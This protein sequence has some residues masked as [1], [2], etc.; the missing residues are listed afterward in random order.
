MYP[1]DLA[2]PSPEDF[3]TPNLT[4]KNYFNKL[5]PSV[6]PKF[7][8]GGVQRK[9]RDPPTTKEYI[10]GYISTLRSL[11]KE[12]SR[13]SGIDPI[14]LNFDED[15]DASREHNDV[16]WKAVG[17][18]DLGKPFKE[19]LKTPFT[20]IIIQKMAHSDMVLNVPANV[21]WITR[22][23]FE[24]LPSESV[25][26]WQSSEGSSR[27]VLHAKGVFKGPYQNKQDCMKG[28]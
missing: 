3:F 4:T 28:E 19:A 23:W 14:R 16:I 24:R 20:Q 27:P 8:R 11:V 17:D 12:H 13:R 1:N 5:T 6:G 10:E 21:R 22:G 15:G 18:A 2:I 7:N 26:E 25:N 9:R